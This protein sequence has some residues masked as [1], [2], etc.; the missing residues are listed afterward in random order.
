[1]PETVIPK[2]SNRATNDAVFALIEGLIGRDSRVLDF[3]A[4]AGY[5]TRRV[6]E[7]MELKGMDHRGRLEACEV[8]PEQFLYDRVD[9]RRASVHSTIPFE[10][11][12]FD[13]IYAI[14]VLE[15]AP[16][17][18]DFFDEA[19]SKLREGGR[20]IFSVPNLL[21]MLSRLKF[22]LTGFGELYPPRPSI[23]RTPA[24]SADT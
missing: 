16:R 12:S 19:Y 13:I 1:M 20:L 10:D 14:E 22:L 17:P 8:A 18:Y 7:L 4:G 3:G 24:G 15:H 9:C 2:G 6:G 5:M 21:H 11:E 23:R